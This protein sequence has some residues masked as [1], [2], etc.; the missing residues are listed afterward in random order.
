VVECDTGEEALAVAAA[1]PDHFDAIVL[2]VT[3]PGKDGYE[4]LEQLQRNPSTAHIPVLLI[5]ASAT[6]TSDVLR[7]LRGGAADH[8]AKPFDSSILVAKV[9]AFSQRRRNERTLRFQ[10]Q[11]AEARSPDSVGR[12]RPAVGSMV[13]DRYRLDRQLGTG[14]TA[15]VARALQAGAQ[16]FTPDRAPERGS[17]VRLRCVPGHALHHDGAPR[18]Y[19]PPRAHARAALVRQDDRLAPAGLRGAAGRA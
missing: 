9:A 6:S 18:R 14:A 10:L 5:T 19:G 2:D 17:C 12:L 15:T 13:A 7:S 3:L 1:G 8:L 11:V 16:R 4:V